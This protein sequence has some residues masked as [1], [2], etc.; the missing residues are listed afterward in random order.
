MSQVDGDSGRGRL[1]LRWGDGVEKYVREGGCELEVGQ[2][3][4]E[5]QRDMKVICLWPPLVG[6]GHQAIDK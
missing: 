3:D 4:D 2:A 1:R 5:E 6:L